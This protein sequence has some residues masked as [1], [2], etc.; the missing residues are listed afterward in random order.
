MSNKKPPLK[1][2]ILR[3]KPKLGMTVKL[4]KDMQDSY[5]GTLKIPAV[6]N[7]TGPVS[8]YPPIPKDS[9]PATGDYYVHDNPLETINVMEFLA[10]E[11][12]KNGLPPE[13]ICDLLQAVKYLSPR[14][15]KKGGKEDLEKDL[16]KIENYAHRA[17]TGE[18]LKET[19]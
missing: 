7:G 1:V 13:T 16:F 18:W 11:W 6:P 3:T 14:L 8:V 5:K 10:K 4:P 17:R 2:S 12:V 9:A 15:G 19:K